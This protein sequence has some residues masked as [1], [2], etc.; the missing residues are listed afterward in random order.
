MLVVDGH[1]DVT[2]LYNTSL[3]LLTYHP[4]IPNHP[5]ARFPGVVVW[6]EIYQVTGPV[7]RFARKIAS[8]GYIV[9]CPSVYH[10]FVGPE[11]FAYD[12][13]GT[14]LGNRYKVEKPVALYD[15]DARLAVEYLQGLAT[16]TGAI[17]STGMCLGGHLAYRTAFLPAVLAT[18]CF[19]ATDIHSGTLGDGDDLLARCGDIRGEII[20]IFGTK[21]NHVPPPGR[22]AIRAAMM[23]ADVA[24]TFMEVNDAQH[25]FVRDESSKGRFDGAITDACFAWLFELFDRRLKL[26]WQAHDGK[27]LVVENVC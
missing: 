2:T 12:G 24:M 25:A 21:D 22:T 4:L 20:M 5:N 1:H 18:V 27:A 7:A 13:P 9:V 16:C 8:H 6:L 3:R 14:D 23:D 19:F 10:N 17:G 15:E 11:P 26:E